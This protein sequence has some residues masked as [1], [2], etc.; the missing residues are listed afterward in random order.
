MER[1]IFLHSHT[2]LEP[3]WHPDVDGYAIA[4]PDTHANEDTVGSCV[5]DANVECHSQWHAHPFTHENREPHA[6]GR[7]HTDVFADLQCSDSRP[8]SHTECDGHSNLQSD[9]DGDSD[10]HYRSVAHPFSHVHGVPHCLPV[11]KQTAESDVHA[12][13]N[14]Y[15]KRNGNRDPDSNVVSPTVS[16]ANSDTEP[17]A[18]CPADAY[19][20]HL[21]ITD[22]D[23]K[24]HRDANPHGN[25]YPQCDRHGDS[26]A[27]LDADTYRHSQPH[28]DGP[29]RAGDRLHGRGTGG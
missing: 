12:H 19:P 20:D 28:S 24:Q 22:C 9:P 26:D 15:A 2:H 13:A 3:T 14:G 6:H 7:G 27:N 5:T 17:V 25:A 18:E 1:H 8:V 11:P 16:D 23:T 21:A 29:P 10:R 4:A